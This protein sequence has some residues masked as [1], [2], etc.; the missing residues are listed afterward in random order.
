MLTSNVLVIGVGSAA[1]DNTGDP[2]RTAFQKIN[3]NFAGL[4]N[5]GQFLANITSSA[6][7][8]SYA[9]SGNVGTGFYLKTPN[10]IGV[11][12]NVVL[13]RSSDYYRG[14]LFLGASSVD[15]IYSIGP[16]YIYINSNSRQGNVFI[17]SYNTY[18]SDNAYLRG[19]VIQDNANAR[20]YFYGDVFLNGKGLDSTGSTLYLDIP[21]WNAI[22]ANS[23][24]S[25]DPAAANVITIGNNTNGGTL[26]L[27][28]SNI[29]ANGNVIMPANAVLR[30]NVES[31]HYLFASGGQLY[32][33]N[34]TST[35]NLSNGTS[36]NINAGNVLVTGDIRVDSS[37]LADNVRANAVII[38]NKSGGAALNFVDDVNDT[39]DTSIYYDNIYDHMAFSVNGNVLLALKANANGNSISFGANVRTSSN[40][41]IAG[42]GVT[43]PTL[44]LDVPGNTAIYGDGVTKTLTL[45]T[46]QN[47]GTINLY[48]NNIVATGNISLPSNRSLNLNVDATHRLFASGGSLFFQNTTDTINI[49]QAVSGAGVT[50]VNG[51]TGA[52]TLYTDNIIQTVSNVFV[53]NT[54]QTFFG[55]KVFDDNVILDGQGDAPGGSKLYLTLNSLNQISANSSPTA[56]DGNVI[57]I[58]ANASRGQIQLNA[59][60]VAS[61]GNILIAN[62]RFL[63][64]NTSSVHRLFASGGSLFFQNTTDTINITQAV[65]GAGV[66]SVNGKTGAVTLVT[67]NVIATSGNTYLTTGTQTFF[68][69]KVFDD[70]VILDGQGDAPGG[71]KLYLTLNSLNQISANSSPTA[72]DGNV[73]YIDA[74]AS[75]GQ[76]QLNAANVASTGNILISTNRFISLNTAATHRIFGSGG[77]LYFQNSTNTL[78]IT[79]LEG[80]GGGGGSGSITQVSDV[81]TGAVSNAR[82]AAGIASTNIS[83][84]SITGNVL[85]G[86]VLVSGEIRIANT[87]VADSIYSNGMIILNKSGGAALNFVDDVNDTADTSIYYDNIYDHMAFSVNSNVIFK[88][89]ANANGNSAV[90]SSNLLPSSNNIFDLGASNFRWKD[91]YLS[92]STIYL[93]SAQITSPGAGIVNLPAG[94]TINGSTIGTS[95]GAVSLTA[96][97]GII[98]NPTTITS[99]GSFAANTDYLATLSTSQTFTG[100]KTF[101]SDV[102]LNGLGP[103][104]NKLYLTL[105]G[106]NGVSANSGPKAYVPDG[107]VIYIDSAG[108][109]GQIQLNAA[110][111]TT[112]G[113]ILIANDRFINLNTSAT[114]RIFGSGGRLYFQNATSTLDITGLQGGGGTGD[115]TSVTAGSGLTGTSESGPDV[116]LNVGQGDGITVSAD[117]VAV[118]ASVVRTSNTSYVLTSNTSYVLI[119]GTQTITGTKTFSGTTYLNSTY[120]T[121]NTINFGAV[122]NKGSIYY[123][124]SSNTYGL[125]KAGT[126]IDVVTFQPTGITIDGT[127]TLPKATGST[128]NFLRADGSWAT[129]PDTD[130][131]TTYGISAETATS[132]A[133]I[134][135]TGSDS[136]IDNVNLIGAG[137]VSIAR[138]DANTITITGSG[139][140]GGDVT[141]VTAGSGL[142]GSSE[143]GPDVTLNV[144]QGD[145]ITVSA[146]AV[147]VDASVVRTSNT[148]YVLTSNTSYVLT[149]TNQ[150]LTGVKTFTSP[151][152]SQSALWIN[153]AANTNYP[154]GTLVDVGDNISLSVKTPSTTSYKAI[155]FYGSDGKTSFPGNLYTT[156]VKFTFGGVSKDL[157]G[158]SDG[159]YYDGTK[160]GTGDVSTSG[161]QTIGGVKT[162]D[163]GLVTDGITLRY[164]NN[165]FIPPSSNTVSNNN[166]IYNDGTNIR[167]VSN[168]TEKTANWDT[169]YG[170][171]NHAS[172]GYGYSNF[173]GSYTDLSNKP[174]IP[175]NTN[176]LTNGSGYITLSSLSFTAGSGGYNSG[177]GVITIPTNTNQLT[178]G[179]NFITSSALAGYATEN[180]VT[181]RGYITSYSETDTLA[182]VTARGTSTNQS[183]STGSLTVTGSITATGEITAYYSSDERL[184]ENVA[185][186]QNPLEKLLSIRGVNFDWTEDYI[187]SRGGEDGYFVRKQD[188]GVIAQEIE[189]VLPEVVA[190]K[191]DGYKAV[192]YEKIVPLLIEAIK[193]QQ[194]QIEELKELVKRLAK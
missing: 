153:A 105:N 117:A 3:S 49:T 79:G 145:G 35:I 85:A 89:N 18:I 28:T 172:A 155:T 151:I 88:L 26:N 16:N 44:Y 45:G 120:L 19:N 2:L 144:G 157:I 115:V 135:I 114:H 174:T 161:T 133:N 104:T 11:T 146:D 132:G 109:T 119:A 14:N 22:Q 125:S 6:T 54:T 130:T 57:Y 101:S 179:A 118:D 147:A 123:S 46:F 112:T 167:F 165:L 160:L 33:K 158:K 37:I 1:N 77:R 21:G 39:A 67:D 116:T 70:N 72:P 170:W 98:A 8:P 140:G 121:S 43:G 90:I 162:F 126:A 149:A 186:I 84:A 32:F 78:D 100:T 184:K 4:Y 62:N 20:V 148:S 180:Y 55:M 92:G 10:T 166:R 30:L 111:T 128:S 71:S 141:S 64:L 143:G 95:S 152:L 91:L 94:S 60:N 150:T 191:D 86:N 66:T 59:A 103:N 177:S 185:V 163:D 136:S 82:L 61:T 127:S 81:T 75:R 53:S 29:V 27:Y 108:S 171:G 173:S 99:S 193:E 42:T 13:D 15:Q 65:S 159:L 190:K 134:R 5:G 36:G 74:N 178:N 31:S 41:F 137:T 83:N 25:S 156:D 80:A 68:G 107:N 12:G 56:P 50:S 176:Q 40:I 52:V 17:D 168:G 58:D 182:T 23:I 169:A 142:T 187:N 102:V 76:I 189:K 188:I 7:R 47:G 110:N 138:T 96:G 87:L 181:T 97:T 194:S 183:L 175:S 63:N 124:L 9:W 131:N 129:P 154:T 93:G 69:M 73:I 192:R 34:S 164:G 38:L 51:K 139:G 113:N 48:A 24:S 106:F 122:N